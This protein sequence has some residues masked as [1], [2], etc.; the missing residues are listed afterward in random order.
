ME[1]NRRR[2]W[3]Y[4][5][6]QRRICKRGEIEDGRGEEGEEVDTREEMQGRGIG[7]ETYEKWRNVTEKNRQRG[8]DREERR[9]RRDRGDET[10]M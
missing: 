2:G 4:W 5:K 7:E 10:E 9:K 3:T 1:G 6:G 8:R